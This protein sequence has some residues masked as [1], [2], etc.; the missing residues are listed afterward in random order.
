MQKV[1][2]DRNEQKINE[3]ESFSLKQIKLE[4][5]NANEAP[6]YGF[7]SKYGT[8]KITD[9]SGDSIENGDITLSGGKGAQKVTAQKEGTYYLTYFIDEDQYHTITNMNH[10]ATNQTV[11]RPT[12]KFTVE[13][14]PVNNNTS[15]T[16]KDDQTNNT[17]RNDQQI[18]NITISAISDK[19]APGKKIK[20]TTNLPKDKVKWMTNNSK[21]ATV[22]K[23][24]VIKINKKQQA[25]R[26]SSQQ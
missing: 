8:W 23:N 1:A 6:Y 15:D 12:V 4:G 2:A 22:D 24:G 11:T 17:G 5:W 21:L 26:L 7:Q 10:Y 16:K 9:A 19:I 18:K 13:K 3:R 14:V 20:L 25:K